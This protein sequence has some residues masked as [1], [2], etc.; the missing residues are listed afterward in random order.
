MELKSWEEQSFSELEGGRKLTR[1]HV[2]TTFQ[3][4]IEGEGTKEYLMAYRDDGS[5]GF[6]GLERVAGRVGDRSGSFVVRHDGSFED[7]TARAALSVVSGSGTGDLRGL[8][9]EGEFVWPHG[10]AGTFTLDYD[11]E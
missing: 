5:A 6:V 1:A 8:R 4:E 10:Q 9:G 3:G 11:L 2:I 7:G